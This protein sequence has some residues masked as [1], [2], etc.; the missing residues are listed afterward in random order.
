MSKKIRYSLVL[1]CV[2]GNTKITATD[3]VDEFCHWWDITW[4]IYNTQAKS[5]RAVHSHN[6]FY[7]G[8]QAS[9]EIRIT[10]RKRATAAHF[11]INC[12]LQERLRNWLMHTHI[13][14]TLL[15]LV[16]IY[17]DKYIGGSWGAF[18]SQPLALCSNCVVCMSKTFQARSAIFSIQH[19]LWWKE[20]LQNYES[21]NV[22]LRH[23]RKS[24][25]TFL[26][27]YLINNIHN[28]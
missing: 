5:V 8:V 25:A 18:A 15:M 26:R 22:H 3:I 11:T 23:I 21:A 19:I 13:L 1:A 9:C 28:A 10:W 4:R 27:L 24:G 7:A 2:L 14:T 6:I 20:E 12:V 16:E 17:L